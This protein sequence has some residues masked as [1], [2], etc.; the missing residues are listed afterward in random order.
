[1]GRR[2]RRRGTDAAQRRQL[3]S[4]RHITEKSARPRD[5]ASPKWPARSGFS[6]ITKALSGH[7]AVQRA[8]G[9]APATCVEKKNQG[10]KAT[11][12]VPRRTASTLALARSSLI[13]GKVTRRYT[14]RTMST[15]SKSTP[16]EKAKDD[17]EPCI[18]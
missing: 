12:R 15:G 9:V 5:S 13:F 8:R 1:M 11:A 18:A 3:R 14:H 6:A 10:T 17:E 4:A 16:S 7:A 2:T